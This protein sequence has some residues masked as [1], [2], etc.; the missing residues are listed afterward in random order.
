MKAAVV[1]RFDQP[2]RYGDFP[3]P[4]AGPD[5][6]LV[7]V[8]ASAL[9]QLTRARAA[10][11]HYSSD[12]RAGFVPGVDGIGRREDG[13]RVYFLLPPAPYGAMAEVTK[14][15]RKCQVEIPDEVG[16]VTMAAAANPMMS[17]WAAL[18]ERARLQRGETVLI[19]GATGTSGRLAVQIAKYLGAGKVIAT[20]RNRASLESL[21]GLGA[22]VVIS[23]EE[24]AEGLARAF[25]REIEGVNIVIDYLWG[26]SAELL[27]AA[28]A[29]Q[30][31]HDPSPRVRFVQIGGMA[32]PTI[33][34]PAAV[35]RGS[36]LEL[37]GSGLG[38]VSLET[39]VQVIGAAAR[40]FVP[41]KFTIEA[42]PMPLAQ[43]ESTWNTPRD[44]RIVYT[45]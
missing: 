4:V 23:L 33:T 26:H 41:G 13:R 39:L 45:V 38:S 12:A 42:E 21:R 35:L 15:S 19:N 6:V 9:S 36:G 8:R 11:K 44:R 40:A 1:H 7:H 25:Q 10:G 29:G 34:L 22:D 3:D 2:P 30:S 43:V 18:T 16:D 5:E 17:S 24:P 31:V 28:V 20:G 27:L 37:L 14:V 32:G